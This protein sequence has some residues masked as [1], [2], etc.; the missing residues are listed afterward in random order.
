MIL[1][2]AETALD[3]PSPQA[4]RHPPGVSARSRWPLPTNDLT[5]DG[6]AYEVMYLLDADD[7]KIPELR[8][9]L[10]GLGRLA[11]GRRWSRSLERPRARG[12]RRR[13]SSRRGSRPAGQH[14]VAVTHFAEQITAGR[15]EADHPPRAGRSSAVT[16]G[17]GLADLFP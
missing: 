10:A 13:G 3:R 15:G 8:R 4:A 1:D 14:R 16:A 11:G 12:R 7:E 5:P 2:A 17:P 6:P 9:A